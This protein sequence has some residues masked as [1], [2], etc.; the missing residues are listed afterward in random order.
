MSYWVSLP[1]SLLSSFNVYLWYTYYVPG[2]VLNAGEPCWAWSRY[3][4]VLVGQIPH[5]DTQD[6]AVREGHSAA[7]SITEESDPIW[8]T[9]PRIIKMR[10]N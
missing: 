10:R 7:E 1:P 2:P 6:D 9:D 3:S 5:D 4:L 8:K